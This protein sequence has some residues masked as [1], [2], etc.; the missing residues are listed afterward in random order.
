MYA[1][2]PHVVVS[3]RD[4]NDKATAD[5]MT[6]FYQ[7]ML[8]D[9]LRPSAALRNAQIKMWKQKRWNAPFY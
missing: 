1:G 9:K 8:R 5:M 2:A 3:L 7:D 4:A 6:L